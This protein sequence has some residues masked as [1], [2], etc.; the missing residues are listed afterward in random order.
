[1]DS[2]VS[3]SL[4]HQVSFLGTTELNGCSN[5]YRGLKLDILLYDQHLP[6]LVLL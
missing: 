2:P 6:L 5:T 3:T 4:I 1:M